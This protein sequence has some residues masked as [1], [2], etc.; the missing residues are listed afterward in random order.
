[1]IRTFRIDERPLSER[2]LGRH[3]QHDDRSRAFAIRRRDRLV[4]RVWAHHGKVLRQ[5]QGSCTGQ[6]TVSC[7]MTEPLY[8]PEIVLD[9]V[10]A[11]EIYALATTL[12][13]IPG[14][15]RSLGDARRS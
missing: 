12:D 7:L 11:V 6:A 3:I 5:H 1:M 14:S 10:A 13:T 9:E 8:S 2:P 4:S 15:Y